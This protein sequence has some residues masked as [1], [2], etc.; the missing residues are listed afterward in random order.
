[1]LSTWVFLPFMIGVSSVLASPVGQVTQFDRNAET[2]SQLFQ[3]LLGSLLT[4]ALVYFQRRQNKNA[5]RLNTIEATA[6]PLDEH[7]ALKNEVIQLKTDNSILVTQGQIVSVLQEISSTHKD[8][9]AILEKY[10]TKQD[11]IKASVDDTLKV[12]QG[13]AAE[14]TTVR[15]AI[16]NMTDTGSK[17]L[18]HL[19]ETTIRIEEQIGDIVKMI[20]A[21]KDLHAQEIREFQSGLDELR[22]FVMSIA[23]AMQQ[24][25]DARATG[26]NKVVTPQTNG[27]TS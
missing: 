5:Q 11:D 20:P 14:I 12:L 16:Q 23:T 7:Q 3:L 19:I 8:T 26:L 24:R 10:G 2:A 25:L 1:M 4:G 6:V 17:P 15:S 27:E 18:Q 22:G 9:K 21:S 13:Q